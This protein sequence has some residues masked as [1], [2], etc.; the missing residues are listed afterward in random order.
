MKIYENILET[1]GDTPIVKLNRQKW[2]I[3]PDILMKLEFFNPGGSLKDRVAIS[4]INAAEKA[5]IL[6][7]NSHIV[8]ATSGNTGISLAMACTV[9][10]YKLTITTPQEI[11]NHRLKIYKILGANVISTDPLKGMQGAVEKSYELAKNDPSVF[12]IKQFSNPANTEVHRQTTA[13]EIIKSCNIPPSALVAG[14]GTG[15]SITGVGEILKE[16]YGKSIKIIGVEPAESPYL[17]KKIRGP[18]NI[19]GIGA[20]M[21][22]PLLKTNIIDEIMPISLEDSLETL[23]KLAIND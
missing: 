4:M 16:E 8:E 18:H 2:G 22:L 17:T 14:I 21:N 5:G 19:Q 3:K 7:K 11:N 1:I 6:K 12:L 23:K 13:R 10:G 9:K 15:G 20:G